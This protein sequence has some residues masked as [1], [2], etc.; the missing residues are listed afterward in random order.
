MSGSSR[1]L[2]ID[3][4]AD[5]GEATTPEH[6]AVE[7]SVIRFVTSVSIACGGHAG[8]EATMLHAV[9]SAIRHG[10]QIGAHPSYLDKERFGRERMELDPRALQESVVEQITA[11][12]AISRSY[13]VSLTHCKPHGALY[14]AASDDES[15]AWSL[16]QACVEHDPDLRLIGQAGSRAVSWWRAW[17]APVSSE[18]FADRVY[19]PDGS[20]RPRGEPDALILDPE[21]AAE[22]AVRI[23]VDRTVRCRNG[24]VAPMS[25]DTICVHADTPG[26]AAIVARVADSLQMPS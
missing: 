22:Q 14:H 23:A 13:G 10:V 21:E 11:L 25:A 3:L 6:R 26:A 18:A 19:E 16:H 4:N 2:V 8:D 7:D 9:R 17:G 5:L 20:L 12:A 1:Q 24:R 15:I